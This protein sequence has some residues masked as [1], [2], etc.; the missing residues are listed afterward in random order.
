MALKA[1]II[2]IY[3]AIATTL[4]IQILAI[5]VVASIP[6]VHKCLHNCHVNHKTA[7]LEYSCHS[8]KT[9]DSLTKC[10]LCSFLTALKNIEIVNEHSFTIFNEYLR[11][12]FSIPEPPQLISLNIPYNPRDPP[13]YNA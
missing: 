11:S 6:S 12:S 8:E 2:G 3:R 9:D 5:L 1:K 7:S 13:L 4:L 10:T